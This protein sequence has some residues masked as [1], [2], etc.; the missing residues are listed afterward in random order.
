MPRAQ[1]PPDAKS[2][3]DAL[4][5]TAVLDPVPAPCATGW[6]YLECY[7]ANK[8]ANLVRAH[9][10]THSWPPCP[11]RLIHP[12]LLCFFRTTP[13]RCS[14]SRLAISV[15]FPGIQLATPP[16]E[17]STNT[18]TD[19]SVLRLAAASH[20]IKLEGLT[21]SQTPDNAAM[22]VYGPNA[23]LFNPI[24]SWIQSTGTLTLS[25]AANTLAYVTI[26][27]QFDLINPAVPEVRPCRNEQPASV[28]HTV[29]PASFCCPR[30]THVA[31]GKVPNSND[32]WRGEPR[33]N[34]G[35]TDSYKVQR[36]SAVR[37]RAQPPP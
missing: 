36:R 1:A 8:E 16:P 4:P 12:A 21:G 33:S 20:A 34:C 27:F 31:G 19:A 30:R 10:D 24:A 14:F 11:L 3:P 32:R 25:T 6:G 9:Q 17:S 26:N 29:W 28:S 5:P 18:A 13:L 7:E 35:D 22:P 15:R 2:P 37:V 23:T